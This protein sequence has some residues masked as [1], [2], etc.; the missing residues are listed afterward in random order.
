MLLGGATP[1]EKGV[2]TP[3]SASATRSTPDDQTCR[4]SRGRGRCSTIATVNE[5]EPHTR[6]K[7]SGVTRQFLTPYGVEFVELP[8][9]QRIYIFDIGGPHTFRTIYMDGRSH[10]ANARAELLRPLDRLVGRRH[11][12]RRH[13]RLQ[14]GL[15]ARSARLAAHRAAAHASSASRAQTQR[16][17]QYELT[18]DDPG[19][20]TKPWTS[21]FD[22]RWDDGNGAVRVRLPAGELRARADGR[23]ERLGRSSQP[24]HSLRA[25]MRYSLATVAAAA[26][27]LSP[28]LTESIQRP[29]ATAAA[30]ASR[31][32]GR[33]AR[34]TRR[35]WC[36][37]A[38]RPGPRP[39]GGPRKASAARRRR[40]DSPRR[41]DAKG[42]GRVVAGRSRIQSAGPEGRAVP[43][44]GEGAARGSP[45]Q[46]ARAAHAMQA[47]RRRASVP[48]AVW[49]R[50]R[51]TSR[52]RACVHLRHRRS[53][54]LSHGVPGRPHASGELLSDL[55]RPFDWLVGRRHAGH[56]H[57]RLQ[58]GLLDGPRRSAPHRQAAHHRAI[59]THRCRGVEVRAHGGRPRR[60]HETVDRRDDAALGGR[61]GALR[62]PVPAVQLRTGADGRPARQGRSV[63]R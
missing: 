25:S 3:S 40:E 45:E 46:R 53:A 50:D 60:L 49:R 51:R 31:R 18:V 4:S 1:K 41:R 7:A 14:R 22:L 47:V 5:L 42:K 38:G 20:Y 28:L 19:A 16:T 23:L 55:L 8:E 21:G 54:H 26:L 63:R 44:M 6:C 52:T 37:K 36:S 61:H 29:A 56:R 15:L 58:R 30:R 57:R 17:M 39:A 32:A 59:D 27:F 12:R 35:W 34:R 62:V 48:H 11:A 2:W 13:G 33:R 10:P 24:H 9:L 43:A